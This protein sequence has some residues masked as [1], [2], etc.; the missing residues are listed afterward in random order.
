MSCNFMAGTQLFE[1]TSFSIFSVDELWGS[2]VL[3]N[4]EIVYKTAHCHIPKNSHYLENLTTHTVVVYVQV[5]LTRNSR[6]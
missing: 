4:F 5:T 1:E 6:F 2:K 3:E